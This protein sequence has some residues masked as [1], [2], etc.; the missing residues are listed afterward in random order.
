ELTLAHILNALRGV[1]AADR[2]IRTGSWSPFMGRLLKEKTV[3]IIG[4][5]RIGRR[6]AQLVEAFG[7][8][9]VFTDPVVSANDD[10][11]WRSLMALCAELYHL[12]RPMFSFRVP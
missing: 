6:V 8:H 11:R 9:V 10:S 1:A 5:G 7:A 2:K 4:F 12:K 3:G